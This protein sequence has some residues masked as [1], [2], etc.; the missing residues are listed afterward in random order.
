MRGPQSSQS[1]PYSQNA[2]PGVTASCPPSLQSPLPAS[3]A[4]EAPQ[5]VHS[6]EH[7]AVAATSG[8]ARA[9]VATDARIAGETPI[10]WRGAQY[11][12]GGG[13]GLHDVPG[14]IDE[15]SGRYV[16]STYF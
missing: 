5:F 7:F 10:F 6:F 8:S 11:I 9:R 4:I 2:Y 12:L 13:V 14:A 15:I 1:V 16:P 3:N